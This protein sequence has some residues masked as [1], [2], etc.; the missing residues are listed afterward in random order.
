MV[1]MD[2]CRMETTGA[3]LQDC[4]YILNDANYFAELN[5]S[6]RKKMA[7]LRLRDLCEEFLDEFDRLSESMHTMD[8]DEE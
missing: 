4:V 1:D 6:V 8:S 2:Y 5:L 7:Y 3:D